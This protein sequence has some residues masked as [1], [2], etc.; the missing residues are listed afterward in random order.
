[1][2]DKGH[3]WVTIYFS[4]LPE[5]SLMTYLFRLYSV[6]YLKESMGALKCCCG[7]TITG[8]ELTGRASL[9]FRYMSFSQ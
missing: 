4:V 7:K 1:M 8:L 3:Y 5:V 6:S 9:L 2:A